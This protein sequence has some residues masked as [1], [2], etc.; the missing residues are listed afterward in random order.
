MEIGDNGVLLEYVRTHVEKELTPDK[1]PAMTLLQLMEE[2]IVLALIRILK[3]VLG[4]AL[5]HPQTVINDNV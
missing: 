5:N 3:I 1:E 2:S 4:L